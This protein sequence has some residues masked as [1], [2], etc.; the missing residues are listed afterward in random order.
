MFANRLFSPTGF[1]GPDP[2][3][4]TLASPAVE[5]VGGRE[6][7]IRRAETSGLKAEDIGVSVA[8]GDRLTISAERIPPT[9]ALGE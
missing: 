9:S 4:L 6:R 8:E 2:S 3:L 1:D 5:H 7:P